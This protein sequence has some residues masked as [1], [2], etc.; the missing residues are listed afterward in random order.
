[1]ATDRL[2]NP[3][4]TRF[5][6][7]LVFGLITGAIAFVVLFALVQLYNLDPAHNGAAFTV[8]VILRT[9]SGIV[10]YLLL[11]QSFL[12]ANYAYTYH[13]GPFALWFVIGLVARSI[14]H[15]NRRAALICLAVFVLNVAL[16]YMVYLLTSGVGP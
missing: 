16:G 2:S 7:P 9:P 8:D 15:S 1:M 13:L 12:Q 3:F 6:Q 10:A 11:P 5:S 14:T 4:V